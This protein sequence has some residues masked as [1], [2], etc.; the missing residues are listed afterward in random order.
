[1]YIQP[2][3]T[4]LFLSRTTA[5]MYAQTRQGARWMVQTLQQHL[6]IC[7]KPKSN[8][9]IVVTRHPPVCFAYAGHE[10]GRRHGGCERKR[11]RRTGHQFD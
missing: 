8:E 9:L 2:K 3:T 1:M 6:D 11:C 5:Y 4:A 7:A 10:Q